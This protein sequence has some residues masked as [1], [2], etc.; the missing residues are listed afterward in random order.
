MSCQK[1]WNVMKMCFW[2]MSET[3]FAVSQYMCPESYTTFSFQQYWGYLSILRTDFPLLCPSAKYSYLLLCRC[4]RWPHR[5]E[6]F[7]VTNLLHSQGTD[8]NIHFKSGLLTSGEKEFLTHIYSKD[9][10][11]L[12]HLQLND[13]PPPYSL[14]RA[15]L[16]T[17]VFHHC[18]STQVLVLEDTK[19]VGRTSQSMC[20]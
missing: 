5:T 14:F 3:A 18:P 16:L 13:A 8:T 17:S 19:S 4:E 1:K 2:S 15:V 9:K 11:T 7:W 20:L 10:K 6:N 12:K